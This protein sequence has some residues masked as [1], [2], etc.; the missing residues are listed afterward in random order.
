[1]AALPL[2]SR[3]NRRLCLREATL[4]FGVGRPLSMPVPAPGCPRLPLGTYTALG[5]EQVQT[6]PW[7]HTSAWPRYVS[8]SPDRRE[9]A[10]WKPGSA[11]WTVFLPCP[12]STAFTARLSPATNAA[13]PPF[14]LA[15]LDLSSRKQ[16]EGKSPDPKSFC[17]PFLWFARLAYLYTHICHIDKFPTQ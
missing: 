8:G 3:S 14:W 17:S 4:M 6:V 1:M 16:H 2:P 5:L 15:T 12:F 10:T 7:E 9:P 13:S 11:T